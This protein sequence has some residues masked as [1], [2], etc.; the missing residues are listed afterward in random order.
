M[1]NSQKDIWSEWLLH[2]R[3]GC[4]PERLREGLSR[5]YPIRDRILSHVGLSETNLYWMSAAAMA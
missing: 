5:L 4:D 2:R 3:F 1:A